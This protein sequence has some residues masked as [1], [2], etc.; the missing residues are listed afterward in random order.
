MRTTNENQQM[1]ILSAIG[2]LLIICGHL[3]FNVL[4]MGGWFPYYSFHI[5]VFLFIS[6]YFYKPESE[7]HILTY[8]K[9]KALH[10]L[11]PYFVWNVFYGVLATVLHQ[12]GFSIGQDISLKTLF[13]TPFLDGHQFLYNYSAW[14]VPALFVIEVINVCMR[15]VLSL[16]RLNNEW[17]IFSVCLIVGIATVWLAKDGHV[18][19]LYKFPGRLLFMYP[20]F[21]MGK[22][23]HDKLEAHDT[24]PNGIY[25]AV[26]TGAQVLLSISCGGLAFSAVWCTGFA[27]EPFVP[28]LSV[29]TGIAFW[30][31]I[32]R[33]IGDSPYL[34]GKMVILGRNTYAIMMHHIGGFMIVK[35]CFYFLNKYTLLFNEFDTELFFSEINFI[36]LPGGGESMKWIYL[37]AGIALPLL[38][39]RLGEII[40][41]RFNPRRNSVSL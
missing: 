34:T 38:I 20:G 37:A 23:Y 3:A 17:L 10:L 9:K 12:V 33:I 7:L 16:I 13:L 4:E 31:R 14:F 15:R 30:L 8:I 2:I 32:A 40:K 36:Y 21:V 11:V 19:G 6:G 1:R 41:C 39:V 35:S 5:F 29:I 28:Y 26:V 22:L 25:F 18:W 24:L 27:N